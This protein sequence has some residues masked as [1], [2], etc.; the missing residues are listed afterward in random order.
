MRKIMETI[1]GNKTYAGGA[2][3][4]ILMIC[5]NLGLID[6][7]TAASLSGIIGALTG[8]SMRHAISKAEKAAKNPSSNSNGTT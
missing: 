6:D 7:K 5:W 2:A 4:L 3:L 8:V 1:N